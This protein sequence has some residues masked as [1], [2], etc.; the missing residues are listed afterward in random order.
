[1]DDC[2][3]CPRWALGCGQSGAVA[4]DAK[5][6]SEREREREKEREKAQ[7][8]SKISKMS[9]VSLFSACEVCDARCETERA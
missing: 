9:A 1:M 4:R 6:S 3:S 5:H 7:S 2:W 8:L